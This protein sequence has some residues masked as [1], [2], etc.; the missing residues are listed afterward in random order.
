M[1]PVDINAYSLIPLREVTDLDADGERA[2]IEHWAK[3]GLKG[4]GISWGK[5][6]QTVIVWDRNLALPGAY[7][8]E[9]AFLH[10]LPSDARNH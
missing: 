10:A 8:L 3:S 2:W 1:S 6:V 7:E 4:S 5:G 9:V